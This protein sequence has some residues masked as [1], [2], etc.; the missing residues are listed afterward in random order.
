MTDKKIFFLIYISLMVF[1]FASLTYFPGQRFKVEPAG[2]LVGQMSKNKFFGREQTASPDMEQEAGSGYD[3]GKDSGELSE[4]SLTEAGNGGGANGSGATVSNQV[5]AELAEDLSKKGELEVAAEDQVTKE[6]PLSAEEIVV[7]VMNSARI[8][9]RELYGN[10]QVIEYSQGKL[11]LRHPQLINRQ[12]VSEY[13]GQYFGQPLLGLMN[14]FMLRN[15]P[16]NSYTL[17]KYK[18]M[19]DILTADVEE[20]TITSATSNKVIVIAQLADSGTN[21]GKIKVRYTIS[22]DQGDSWKITG[23]TILDK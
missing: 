2:S 22:K 11:A 16:D 4:S 18:G 6:T 19:T 12:Q 10:S 21:L 5:L 7:G 3:A 17:V 13:F 14:L 9:I 15:T 8:A 20:V 23:V 1:L